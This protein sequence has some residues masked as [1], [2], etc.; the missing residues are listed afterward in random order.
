MPKKAESQSPSP[1]PRSMRSSS[2]SKSRSRSKT[3]SRSRES[4]KIRARSWSPTIRGRSFSPKRR[5]S[6]TF[7]DSGQAGKEYDDRR[8]HVANL[9]ID[10]C[11]KD[12][13]QIFGRFGPLKE[14]WMARSIP[15]FAFVIYRERKDTLEALR[16]ADG[17][18]ICGRPVRVT[19]AHKSHP[20][21]RRGGCFSGARERCFHCGGTSHFT[22]DC[23]HG[24]GFK[25]FSPPRGRGRG[26][27]RYHSRIFQDDRRF[28]PRHWWLTHYTHSND[29]A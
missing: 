26:R 22:R 19:L 23:W 5:F 7:R 21:E 2:R 27:G 16:K 4:F 17:R 12:M 18:E 28:G 20:Y 10:T 11:Q 29:T 13:E 25:K 9:D 15:C 24:V 14:I 8:L 1:P 3:R 6:D